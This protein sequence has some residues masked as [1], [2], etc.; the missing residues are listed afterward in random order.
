MKYA[1]L[2]LNDITAAPGISVTVFTQGCPHK[3]PGCHN[4]DTWNKNAG[5]EIEKDE[6]IAKVMFALK[7]RDLKRN[8]CIMGGEPLVDYNIDF[9]IDLCKAVRKESP[10]TK[11]YLW[12]GYL[13]SDIQKMKKGKEILNNIDV[14]IDGPY[15]EAERDITIPLRGSRN[16]SIILF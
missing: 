2:I 11:I 5:F 8:L 1:G 12:S 10:K 3:C 15:V 6:L 14:L 16:Q 9:C 7:D 13:I 4:P